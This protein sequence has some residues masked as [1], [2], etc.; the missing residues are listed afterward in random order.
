MTVDTE[1]ITKPVMEHYLTICKM[2]D[3]KDGN[4]LGLRF[5]NAVATFSSFTEP[6]RTITF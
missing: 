2:Y 5:E 6:P 4:C 1:R 3:E